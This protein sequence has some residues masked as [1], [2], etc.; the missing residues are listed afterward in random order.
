MPM[1][2]VLKDFL[3]TK[4]VETAYQFHKKTG[5]PQATAYRLYNKR[6]VYPDQKTQEIVC[7]VFD[8]Q[9]GEFLRYEPD[10]IG[11]ECSQSD[12]KPTRR[13]KSSTTEALFAADEPSNLVRKVA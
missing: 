5:L 7:R 4:G 9:P 13:T 1:I 3:A 10:D 11:N 8:V 6:N 12:K 2:N